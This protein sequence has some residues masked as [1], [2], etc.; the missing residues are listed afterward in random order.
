MLRRMRMLILT[1]LLSIAA[2]AIADTPETVFITF[3]PKAGAEAELE[4][5]IAGHWETVTR[6]HLVANRNRLIY[7]VRESGGKT[8]FLQI[9]TWRDAEIPDH[10]PAQVRRWWKEME[11]LGTVEF[12]EVAA[13][14]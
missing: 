9:L 6:L 8:R 4:R 12:V 7:R 5:V 11:R 1:L 2:A 10:A 3:R 13:V 14:R